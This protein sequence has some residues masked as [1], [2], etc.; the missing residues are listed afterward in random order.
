VTIVLKS[1]AG[2]V[3]GT[4][5]Q[6][7]DLKDCSVVLLPEGFAAGDYG[8]MT[9][10]DPSGAFEFTGIPP[11]S[12]EAIALELFRLDD[13]TAPRLRA[14]LS[15]A[16]SVRVESGGSASIELDLTNLQQ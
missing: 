11:G 4:V 9:K 5:K 1:D 7:Q 12:Y 16:A 8:R 14:M 6:S 2:S 10:C 3:R 13:M 15:Q